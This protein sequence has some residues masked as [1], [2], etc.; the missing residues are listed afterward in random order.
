MTT[1]KTV[2][3][4]AAVA[5]VA[6]ALAPAA[7]AGLVGQLG[8]LDE[9]WFAANPIN[10]DT[11]APWQDG[12]TYHLAFV[13]F[14]THDGISTDIGVYNAF[15]QGAAD[16]AGIGAT[17]SVTWYAIASTATVDAKDNAV[18]SAPVY[19]MSTNMLPELVATNAS[20]MWDG[21]I[22]GPILYTE[23][24]EIPD[25]GTYPPAQYAWT[26]S[27]PSGEADRPLGVAKPMVGQSNKADGEWIAN[28]W[29]ACLQREG[30][31][32]Y[33]LSEALTVVSSDPG[34]LSWQAATS[35]NWLDPMW[36]TT[37]GTPENLLP[38]AGTAM[39][40]NQPDTVVTVNSAVAAA[41]SVDV[42]ATTNSQLIV[43][44][45]N[46]LEVIGAVD[47]AANATLTVNGT[48]TAA[49]ANVAGTLAGTGTLNVNPITVT[50]IVAPGGGGIGT[51]T[52]GSGKMELNPAATFNA[53]VSLAVVEP[54][55]A[56]MSTT[57]AADQLVLPGEHVALQIGGT[58]AISSLDD[59]V[60]NG[61]WAS[62]PVIID[63]PD[64]GV[65]TGKTF[66]AVTPT[67][68]ASGEPAL[69]LGQGLF[70]QAGEGVI[71]VGDYNVTNAVELDVL[72]ALGGDANGDGKVWL[73][74]W[75]ALRTNFGNSGTGKTWTEG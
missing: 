38:T 5:M 26:G 30:F 32:L 13:T 37:P 12:E 49:S 51:L 17:E 4:L 18:V 22:A 41:L 36:T 15:V 62:S 71:Y 54:I 33:G 35:G 10:P 55:E 72:V 1:R 61:Y 7:Q 70:L 48:L 52:L 42:G 45:P 65:V 73:E 23:N 47:V 60:D 59:R 50:G 21:D 74:D 64:N 6:L 24:R 66:N 44:D 31:R 58:L 63:N 34:S 56:D 19:N 25:Y 39:T 53:Q 68:P 43:G 69:H 9:A 29:A 14:G 40:I 8:I 57:L 27:D 2:L 28:Y 46:T 67:P 3:T 20:D 75:A 11:A 16:A